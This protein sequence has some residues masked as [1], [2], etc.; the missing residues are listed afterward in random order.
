MHAEWGD[1]LFAGRVEDLSGAGLDGAPMEA[2]AAE[3]AEAR[4]D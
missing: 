2:V 1:V 4:Q 3:D